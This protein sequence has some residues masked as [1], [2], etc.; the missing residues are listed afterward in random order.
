M[1]KIIAIITSI[2]LMILPFTTSSHTCNSFNV[3]ADS[4]TPYGLSDNSSE[5]DKSAAFSGET[6]AIKNADILDGFTNYAEISSTLQIA[7]VDAQKHT[8]YDSVTDTPFTGTSNVVGIVQDFEAQEPISGATVS[9]DGIFSVTTDS[10]GRFQITNMPDGVYDWNISAD[11]YCSSTYSNYY[12]D[13]L[14]G[15]TIFTFDVSVSRDMSKDRYELHEGQ[16]CVPPED[17]IIDMDTYGIS[18]NTLSMSSIPQVD[19]SFKILSNGSVSTVGRQ[20]YIGTVVSSELYP[21]SYYSSKGLTS[22]QIKSLHI[23]QA[24]VANTFLEYALSV[25]SNHQGSS[26]KVCSSAC[27]QVYDTSKTTSEGL[28]AATAIFN[29]TG[30]YTYTTLLLYHPSSTVY[31]YIWGAFFSS[32][33]GKGTLTHSSQPSLKSVSCTDLASGAGGH[34]YG[35]CQ[36]GA[37]Y[38]AKNTTGGYVTILQHYFSNVSIAECR[39]R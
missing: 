18:A 28:A 25:Y 16:Q 1:K 4:Y 37:A 36:M 32:C 23:A 19:V 10:D 9:V 5:T 6:S 11:G 33:A 3:Y 15:T 20:A 31:N 29:K 13:H 8:F 12:V 2:S 7:G 27:C 17:S 30:G 26:Y 35:L 22:S 14:E 21:S 34:R 39:L 38:R 24:V